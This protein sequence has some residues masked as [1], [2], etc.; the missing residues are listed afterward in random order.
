MENLIREK[1]RLSEIKKREYKKFGSLCRHCLHFY[2]SGLELSS[3]S[4]SSTWK[5]MEQK[6]LHHDL[7]E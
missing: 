2:A 3:I 6:H 7:R 1:I 4:S 5:Q